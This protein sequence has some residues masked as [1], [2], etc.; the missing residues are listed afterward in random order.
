MQPKYSHY[1]KGFSILES[2]LM[3]A[4]LLVFCIV[5]VGVFRKGITKSVEAEDPLWLKKG[6]DESMKTVTPLPA[7]NLAPESLR[8]QP[9]LGGETTNVNGPRSTDDFSQP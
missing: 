3:L 8:E 5:A 9:G 6:G 2:L 4:L 1:K 7:N